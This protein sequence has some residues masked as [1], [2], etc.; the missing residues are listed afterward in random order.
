MPHHSRALYFR[1]R[2]ATARQV[3]HAVRFAGSRGTVQSAR[4]G[5]GEVRAVDF[6]HDEA[7]QEALF[8]EAD[9]VGAVVVWRDVLHARLGP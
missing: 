2:E 6:L 7:T 9:I 8:G 3:V 4:A 5:E 1:C